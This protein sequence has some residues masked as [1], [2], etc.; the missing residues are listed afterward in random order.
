MHA[1]CASVRVGIPPSS[2]PLLL[3]VCREGGNGSLVRE[4][5][6][7]DF[8]IVTAANMTEE[9]VL[10]D[11]EVVKVASEVLELLPDV[12]YEVSMSISQGRVR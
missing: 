6:Q 9:R 1:S 5:F 4:Y 11:A 2:Q 7:A 8:D 10:A 3:Q 12:S